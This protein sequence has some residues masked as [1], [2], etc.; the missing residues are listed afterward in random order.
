M[1]NKM[2]YI[3][4]VIGLLLVVWGIAIVRKAQKRET[5]IFNKDIIEDIFSCLFIIRDLL[6]YS[7]MN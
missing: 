4:I 5:T 3:I 6:V 2:G 1:N 7:K